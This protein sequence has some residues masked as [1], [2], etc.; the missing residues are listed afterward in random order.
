MKNVSELSGYMTFHNR[1]R[2]LL[3]SFLA[4]F[5]NCKI[6][7]FSTAFIYTHSEHDYA[8]EHHSGSAMRL[9]NERD[10]RRSPTKGTA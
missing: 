9:S 3:E 4:S 7:I 5:L 1:E 8:K 6:M 2:I 10:L